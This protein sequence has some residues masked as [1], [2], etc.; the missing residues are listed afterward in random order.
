[1]CDYIIIISGKHKQTRRYFF[2]ISMVIIVLNDSERKK[3]LWYSILSEL[4]F[5]L[6]CHIVLGSLLVIFCYFAYLLLNI[7]NIL[8]ILLLLNKMW[9]ELICYHIG[10]YLVEVQL[11]LLLNAAISAD[12]PMRQ[13]PFT[14][15]TM[16]LTR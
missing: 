12:Q 16:Q 7:A 10:E 8:I 14:L 15:L 9:R 3:H 13:L 11:S 4:Y 1:M 6:I 2:K 5:D